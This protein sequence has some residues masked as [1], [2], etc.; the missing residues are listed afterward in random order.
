MAGLL[1]N[2]LTTPDRL[3]VSDPLASRREFLSR[4]FG[5]AVTADNQAAVRGADIVVLCV[6]PQVLDEVLRE[7]APALASHPLIIS[8]AAGYPLSRMRH[9]LLTATRLIRAMPNTPSTIG[10]GVTAMSLALDMSSEDRETA[11]QLFES[12]GIAVVVEERLLDAVTGLSGSGPA[13]V[14]AMIEALA[15]G[16]VLAGLPRSTAQLLAAHTVAGAAGMVLEQGEH[17]AVLKDRVASPGGTTISGLNQL[18]RGKLRA[19]LMSAVEAA[20]QRSQ[21]LGKTEHHHL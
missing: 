19:T 3:A 18:E 10:E 17:P 11:R 1:R 5:V 15:D 21:E 13:Y 6:E 20:T 9:H 14:F 7:L 2:G 4:T 12:V 8:V 16:G